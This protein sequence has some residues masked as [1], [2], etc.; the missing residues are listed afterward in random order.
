M[1]HYFGRQQFTYVLALLQSEFV[2]ESAFYMTFYK[3]SSMIEEVLCV[4]C[5]RI[6]SKLYCY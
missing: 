1:S 2:L 3:P 6:L 4:V 5:V